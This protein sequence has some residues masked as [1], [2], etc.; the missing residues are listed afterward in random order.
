MCA[1]QCHNKTILMACAHPDGIILFVHIRNLNQK[2]Y[3]QPISCSYLFARKKQSLVF[4]L[5]VEFFLDEFLELFE[6]RCPGCGYCDRHTSVHHSYLHVHDHSGLNTVVKR[7]QMINIRFPA[8][9][10]SI[11]VVLPYK[12]WLVR[13]CTRIAH[14]T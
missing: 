11:A 2:Q 9:V 10:A 7:Y 8:D 1:R 4:R 12:K 5:D 13:L 14:Y 3:T 6:H